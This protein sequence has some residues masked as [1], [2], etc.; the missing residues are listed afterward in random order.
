[1]MNLVYRCYM[2]LVLLLF[3]Y[4]LQNQFPK[5]HNCL[6]GKLEPGQLISH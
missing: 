3:A 4:L 6:K 2:T 5:F 1:M